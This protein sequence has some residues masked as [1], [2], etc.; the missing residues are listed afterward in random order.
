MSYSNSTNPAQS[1]GT[2][3]TAPMSGVQRLNMDLANAFERIETMNRRVGNLADDFGASK[4]PAEP[5]TPEAEVTTTDVHMNN[6]HRALS[7][8]EQS[9]ARIDNQG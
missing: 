9:I 2:A 4:N 6:L 5:P 1:L 8:L 3:S 7:R